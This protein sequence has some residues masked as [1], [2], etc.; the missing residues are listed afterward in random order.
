MEET[1]FNISALSGRFWLRP[2]RARFV[3]RPSPAPDRGGS[4]AGA[5]GGWTSA[6][7]KEGRFAL[8]RVS[9]PFAVPYPSPPSVADI[10]F[11]RPSARHRRDPPAI[12]PQSI[13][14]VPAYPAAPHRGDRA[15]RPQLETFLV[16]TGLRAMCLASSC[17]L[18]C[19][20]CLLPPTHGRG[21]RGRVFPPARQ[22]GRGDVRRPG[23]NG[24]CHSS[25][26]PLLPPAAASLSS[27]L[28]S[29]S[30]LSAV[31]PLSSRCYH[32]PP[33]AA[34]TCRPRFSARRRRSPFAATA[35]PIPSPPGVFQ[36]HSIQKTLRN[37]AS[38]AESVQLCETLLA[39]VQTQQTVH[40]GASLRCRVR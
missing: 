33:S 34:V 16:R 10:A 26:P 1:Y 20:I 38:S 2:G 14:M 24:L 32:R 23:R 27:S 37:K 7:P 13:I 35:F 29:L 15:H 31:L 17:S 9:P 18:K 11:L 22:G 12:T 8:L 28:S 19:L 6:W 21:F 36:R 39:V 25:P 4:G 3:E 5:D 30:S 40:C